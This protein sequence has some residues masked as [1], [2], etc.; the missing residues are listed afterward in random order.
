[1]RKIREVLRLLW[2][3]ERSVREVVKSCLLARS[4][5]SEY[6]RRASAAGLAW[7]LPTEDDA[8]L[9]ALLFPPAPSVAAASRPLPDWD[10]VDRELKRRKG[11]TRALLWEEY[12]AANPVG[13][14]YTRYC[15]LFQEW[16]GL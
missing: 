14:S 4:T 11:V 16:R 9:E 10:L 12:R 6:E 7:P 2:D 8:V 13:Y 1:M 3:Q 15:E 5:V